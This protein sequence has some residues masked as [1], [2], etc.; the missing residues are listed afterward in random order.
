[1]KTRILIGI[2]AAVL[3]SPLASAQAGAADPHFAK[4]VELRDQ[5]TSAYNMGEYDA[6]TGLARQAKAE[7]ALARS[8]AVLPSSYTVRLIPGDRDC[9]SKI[10]GYPFVYGDRARWAMLYE[11]NKGTLKHPEDADI[12]LPG[13]V[14]IIPSIAGEARNGAWEAGKTY[15]SL[16]K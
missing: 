16:G 3:L 6:A 1:M 14:L 11:A 12:L 13:E 2:L 7:L 8:A 15:P 9:L 10:A 5:A 4:A